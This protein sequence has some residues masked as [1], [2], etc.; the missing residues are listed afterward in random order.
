MS[1]E[2]IAIV[3]ASCR[4]PG[5]VGLEAFWRLLVDGIDAVSEIG[6]ERWSTRFFY[7]PR[8]GEPGKTYSFAAGLIDDID[9][10]EPGFFGIS[11]REAAEMDPQQRLLL[12]L[13][14]HALED[15]GIPASRLAGST[16]GVYIGASSTDYGELRLGDP[17]SGDQYFIAGMTLSILANRVSHIFDLRG[18]SVVI[19]TACS[20]SLVALH[21]AC[22]ALLGERIEAALV[23]GINL[24]L[25]PYPFLGFAQAAMLSRRGRCFAFDARADGYVRGEGGGVVVLKRL[26]RALADGDRVRAVIRATAVSSSGR[27]MG[28]SLP[29]ETAQAELLR[30]VYTKAG[31]VPDELAF[32]EM[33]GTGTPVGDPAEAAAVGNI[34]GR[35]RV[36][37]LPIGSVKTNIGHLEPASGVAGLLKTMLALERGVLPPSLHGETPNPE[38]P[39]DRLN[40]RLVRAREALVSGVKHAGV[41]SFGFGGTNAHAILAAPPPYKPGT[42]AGTPRPPLLISARSEASLVAL[43]ADW[44]K[45]LAATAPEKMPLLLRAAAR[46][47]DHHPHRLVVVGDDTAAALRDFVAGKANPGTIAGTAPREG[48]LAFV[49]S[50]NGAQF[51]TMGQSAYHTSASFRAGMEV[52]DRALAPHLGWSVAARVAS[53][54]EDDELRRANIAQ[55]LLFAI[56]IAVTEVLRGFGVAPS[57]FVGHSVGEITAAWAAGALSSDDAARIVVVRSWHQERTRGNGRM[58]A[59]ALGEAEAR[60]L[61]ADLS[62]RIEIAAINSERS[63]TV[64]GD[65][66]AIAA[67]GDK[68]SQLGIA[69]RALDLD[70][71]F[72]SA[73]MEPIRE[74]LVG[75]LAEISSATPVSELV[76]TVTGGR[77]DSGTLD[78]SHWWRNIRDPVRFADAV[79]ALIADSHRIFVEIGPSPVL[80]SHLRDALRVA[81][82]V[83]RV[84]TT[85]DRHPV[86]VDPFLAILSRLHVAGHDLSTAPCFD[87]PSDPRGLPFYQW[88]R[89]R[90]WFKRT[91]E[92]VRQVNPIFDHPLLG[93]RQIG[94]MPSWLNHLDTT[95]FPFLADHRIDGISVLPAA[96]TI[97]MALA[98]ALS[99]HPETLALE[100][101]DVELLRPMTFGEDESREVRGAF[102]SQDGDWQ[103]MSRMRLGDEPMTVHATARLGAARPE[104][105]LTIVSDR[106]TC[107]IVSSSTLYRLAGQFGLDYEESFR[108]VSEVTISGTDCAAVALTPALVDTAPGYLIHPMLLD[109]AL[110]GLLALLGD[111]IDK[112]ET[113]F[114]PRRFGRVRAFAP[115]GRLPARAELRLTRRAARSVAADIALYDNV[116]GL[117]AEL[118]DCWFARVD[119]FRSGGLAD[120]CL[121]IEPVPAPLGLLPTLLVLDRLDD[122]LRDIVA[123]QNRDP[124][125]E[126]E[127][128]LLFDA[129]IAAGCLEALVV[130]TDDETAFTVRAL[131]DAGRIAPRSAPLLER[132]LALLCRFGAVIAEDGLWRIAPENDLPDVGE[133]WRTMLA[134][135]PDMVTELAAVATLFEALPGMLRD[136]A[137]PFDAASPVVMT[138]RRASLPAAAAKTM[139]AAALDALAAEW[140]RDRTLRLCELDDSGVGNRLGGSGV[141]VAQVAPGEACDIALCIDAGPADLS[142]LH[143]GLV[144][145]GVLLTI[146]PLP[147]ALWDLLFDDWPNRRGEL[148]VLGFP[149]IGSVP[150]SPAPWPCEVVWARSASGAQL[151]APTLPPLSLGVIAD[152]VDPGFIAAIETAGHSV[153]PS[154]TAGDGVILAIGAGGDPV[155]DAAR[156]LPLFAD[157]AAAAA[158]RQVPLWL[159]TSGAQQPD[160]EVGL[161]AAGLWGFGRVLQNEVQGLTLRRVDLPPTLSWTERAQSVLQELAAANAETEIVWTSAGR[162]ALRLRR[163]LPPV[164]AEPGE[165]IVASSERPG[166]LERLAW[167]TASSRSLESGEIEIE[168]HAVGVNF[169]DVMCA[170]GMLPDEM[171]AGGFAGAA[172]GLE[173]AGVVRAVGD[174]VGEV[175][176]GDRVVGFAPSAMAGRA[177]T[178]AD[179]VI[180][181]P[182]G[183]DFRAAATLPV[184]FVTAKYSLDS[185]ARLMPGEYVLVHSASGGVGLAAIQIAKSRGAFVIATAGSKEKRAFLR[186]VGADYVCDSRELSFIATVRR[187]TGGAG[188]DVVL[189]SLHGEGME[190]SLEL[191]KPFGRF[192]EL[193]K[194]DFYENRRLRVRLLRQNIAYFA[195]DVDQMPVRRPEL[196]KSLLA[197]LSAS[198]EAGE[199]Q[200][201]AHRTFAF[202][203]IG[204]AFRLMQTA[205]HIGKVVLA[206]DGYAGI[207]VVRS[208]TLSLRRDATYV[209]TG[210]LNGFGFAAARWLAE[211]GAGH[212]ALIG[213]R[214]LETA[215]AAERIVEL[216]ALGA[217][218]GAYAADVADPTALAVTL[219]TIRRGGPPIRGVVHAAAEITNGMAGGI[220]SADIAE[221]FRAKLGGAVL[222]D[223]LTCDDPLDLFWLFS[224]ATTLIGAP[225]QGAYVAANHAIEALA[226]RRH[227]E[228]RPA[229][230]VA[231]GPIAD[232]GVLAERPD[233]RAALARRFGAR[234]TPAAAALSAL[235]ALEACG[236]P[237]IAF[238]DMRW[239]EVRPMLPILA[240]PLFEELCSEAA[241]AVTDETLLDRLTELDDIERRELLEMMVADEAARVLRLPAAGMDRHRPL[242]EFGMDSLMAIE[243]RLAIETRL[244]I[245]LPL[246]TLTEGTTFA[247]LALR[248][249]RA[250]TKQGQSEIVADLA[251]RYETP[252]NSFA[253]GAMDLAA[254]E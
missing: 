33:H 224:S 148:A 241:E 230:A 45:T 100:L 252:L 60:L 222:L 49:Y 11:P 71:A 119:L 200:P 170:M 229:L 115:F 163:G 53:G 167:T 132:L 56:Q 91:A 214:G 221:A 88:Q 78:A 82:A 16:T 243:L 204:N 136:G 223:R 158:K 22:E 251:V 160:A 145:G 94:V 134:E 81:D 191:L 198:L 150:L 108:T 101:L 40:L 90:H 124:V 205:Q 93:F 52:A 43:A 62:S 187:A 64:A 113:G 58:A 50:G 254:D 206:P 103:L 165:T 217:A 201:L 155:A 169:R 84:V 4:F 42:P 196:A 26:K 20:S 86:E 27:T 44:E 192:V 143:D 32:V 8:R 7:H 208:P 54:I 162:H 76:S 13:A 215:G 181:I 57:G 199:I 80:S 156:L 227:A 126:A 51:S 95:L 121:R 141:L 177:V 99:Q 48:R 19:D 207:A 233:E 6:A 183:L 231:W 186:L 5:A 164:W 138:L 59:L 96:A 35:A 85:L 31:I 253:L 118:A 234:A 188:V 97:E 161:L 87:G 77:V 244:R 29:S 17:A 36:V 180:A 131:T 110:Q 114:L 193:G 102:V 1:D 195:V 46:R 174:N 184:A 41:N 242:A 137:Y 140:P 67:L 235:P 220:S 30:E 249:D 246:M 151:A 83:G 202:A 9:Q 203:E 66:V 89:E 47:R 211:Q 185:L 133:L 210:G 120:R 239:K 18:P 179:A 157:L 70:F 245:D 147:N 225:G 127:R 173:C 175:A 34:L 14:W 12:E 152:G 189:N 190:A 236:L 122:I 166:R 129:L 68:A 146:G 216:E 92:A 159:V 213:R 144:P 240:A 142:L 171:L 178:R 226:R 123:A 209:V 109:G 149:N 247:T 176:L 135:A 72:H 15:A 111:D 238:A 197:E 228:G 55:P 73:T 10:F 23:G 130:L 139:I 232:A 39:F 98:A 37:T 69:W 250:V 168:V 65:L 28:L 218:V 112:P 154:E 194:R 38:I 125:G 219:D 116:G 237:V 74:D 106:G 24:L 75:D 153:V 182:P 79:A 117:I 248:L 3:G 63:V 61:L 105:L 107:R 128:A 104:P 212:L 172:L 25:S 2:A 21:H